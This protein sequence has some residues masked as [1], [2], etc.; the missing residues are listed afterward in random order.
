MAITKN[1]IDIINV[2][3]SCR[4][5]IQELYTYESRPN[6]IVRASNRYAKLDEAIR[7]EILEYDEFEDELCLSHDTEEYYKTRLGQNSETY[8]GLISEKTQ[9]LKRELSNYNIR[10]KN[11]ES[12]KKE[13]KSIYKI[14]SQIPSLL[15]YNLHAIASNSIFTFKNEPNFDIKM[16]N[17][18]ICQNEITE[19]IDASNSVD[20]ILKTEYNFLKSMQSKKINS[21]IIKLKHNSAEIEGA[22][23]K[24]Y[25][26]I[27]N[28]INQSIK[29]GEFIKKLQ[30]LKELKD[31]NKLFSSSNI[32]ELI[33]RNRSIIPS[34]RV[35]KIHPD[36]R[37]HDYIDTIR[38][39]I[40]SRALELKTDK[41]ETPLQFDI[42]KK[43]EVKKRLYNYQK[44]NRNFLAQEQDLITFLIHNEIENE[45]LLGVFVRM[46]KNFYAQYQINNEK[47]ITI[48]DRKYIEI[49]SKGSYDA[50]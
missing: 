50:H 48:D 46:L 5:V 43:I 36:D 7:L 20:E 12:V 28:Y 31:E 6:D 9:K 33:E 47:F 1:I 18:E 34:K 37:I 8:I 21:V 27:K 40:D 17:L 26:D 2:Q 32:E 3:N 23:G 41:K 29:D 19:L 42:D 13:I 30:H 35:K 25:D 39:I 10:I 45:R 4:E 49:F 15:K 16:L 38:A 24:L 22:F 44:L 14:L 11:A